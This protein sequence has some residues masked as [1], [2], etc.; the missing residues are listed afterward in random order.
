M[1][2]IELTLLTAS[3]MDLNFD[4]IPDFSFIKDDMGTRDC[5]LATGSFDEKGNINITSYT[6]HKTLSSIK[7]LSRCFE[8]RAL[9]GL[10]Y[11][12]SSVIVEYKY[13]SDYQTLVKSEE[14]TET[15]IWNTEKIAAALAGTNASIVDG[16]NVTIRR[17]ECT[18]VTVGGYLTIARDSYGRYYIKDMPMD[19]FYRLSLNPNGNWSKSEKVSNQ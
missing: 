17:S 14:L 15:F 4:G 13:Q 12:G 18:A 5:W 16:E 8:S 1:L 7:S 11:N 19:G 3:I 9:Y 10:D 6:Y 2:N